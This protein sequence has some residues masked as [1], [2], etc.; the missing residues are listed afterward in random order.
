MMCFNF[1]QLDDLQIFKK[2]KKKASHTPAL[3]NP[4]PYLCF[5]VLDM[6]TFWLKQH[7]QKPAAQ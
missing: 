4:H 1:L 5:L 2:K 7:L 6:V 3:L